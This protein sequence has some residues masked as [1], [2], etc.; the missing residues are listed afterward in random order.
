LSL[1]LTADQ[2][3]LRADG[4][5]LSFLTLEIIDSAG[6]VVPQAANNITYT[7]SGPG[8]IAAVGSA[9]LTTTES[10]RANPRHA[11]QG[12]SLVVIRSDSVPGKITVTATA[13]DLS[14]ATLK[15]S[16]VP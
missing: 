3:I 11:F 5:C 2:R 16:S 8:T 13:P 15:L 6:R 10:Y 12:R 7:V 9:D 1:R 4:E 14:P